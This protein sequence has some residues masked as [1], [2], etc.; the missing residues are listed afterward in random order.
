MDADDNSYLS[1]PFADAPAAT[2]QPKGTAAP[3]VVPYAVPTPKTDAE[4]QAVLTEARDYL[5]SH[6]N[7]SPDDP[8]RQ[9]FISKHANALRAYH[10]KSPGAFSDA[11]VQAMDKAGI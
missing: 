10:K 3:L 11:I 6:S 7:V 2:A 4:A 9:D 5:A 8:Q 1:Y